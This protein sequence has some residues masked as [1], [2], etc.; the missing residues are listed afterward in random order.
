MSRSYKAKSSTSHKDFSVHASKKP[1]FVTKLKL[2]PGGINC[3]CCT[4]GMH[5][6][7]LKV[8]SR[9]IERRKLKQNI[10]LE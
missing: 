9:R 6:S 2:G 7:K 1:L 4:H 8:L 5:P 3:S 10:E